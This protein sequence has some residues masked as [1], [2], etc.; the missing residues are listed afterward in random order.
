MAYLRAFLL[1][2][3]PLHMAQNGVCQQPLPHS[4]LLWGE[5]ICFKSCADRSR[6]ECCFCLG[7]FAGF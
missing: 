7:W 4:V 3:H 6:A 5:V 1:P 2:Q